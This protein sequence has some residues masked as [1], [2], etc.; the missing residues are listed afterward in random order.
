MPDGFPAVVAFDERTRAELYERWLPDRV[1]FARPDSLAAGRDVVD[2]STAVALVRH[3]LSDETRQAIRNLLDRRGPQCRTIVTTSSHS[4]VADDVLDAEHCL[5][6]PVDR[7]TFSEAVGRQLHLSMYAALLERYYETTAVVAS[8]EVQL[9]DETRAT[10]DRYRRLDDH[11]THL[12]AQ[13]DSVE[14][15]LNPDDV[16]TLMLEI[17][18]PEFERQ[19]DERPANLSKY[20]PD[21]CHKCGRDWNVTPDGSRAGYK[22]LS[23]FVWKCDECGIVYDRSDP[24]NNQ[25]DPPR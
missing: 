24:T 19:A 13:L 18:P 17:V 11:V 5:S 1:S 2:E 8:L 20:R 7:E 16:R 14:A 3:E 12:K 21:H 25:I 22:R 15:Y 10:H 9:D 4:P 6:E 23:S